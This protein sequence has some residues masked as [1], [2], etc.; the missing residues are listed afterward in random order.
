MHLA[1][2]LVPGRFGAYDSR[3][4]KI[5]L[6]LSSDVQQV[7]KTAAGSESGPFSLPRPPAGRS[8][9]GVIGYFYW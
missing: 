9:L 8:R 4:I 5:S 7:E 6:L 1:G 3:L 2:Y